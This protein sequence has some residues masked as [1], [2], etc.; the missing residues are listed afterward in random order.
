MISVAIRAYL[1]SDGDDD[2]TDNK[3][4]VRTAGPNSL[5]L[6]AIMP[7]AR[8]PAVLNMVASVVEASV[9]LPHFQVLAF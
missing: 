6:A 5:N 8:T 4:N 2:H 7:Y 1:R 3:M 9:R